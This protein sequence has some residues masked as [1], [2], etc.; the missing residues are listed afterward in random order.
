[1]PNDDKPAVKEQSDNWKEGNPIQPE[2][3]PA[4][5]R[6]DRLIESLSEMRRASEDLEARIAD[7]RRHNGMPID[8]AL[9]NPNWEREAADG[10]LD[11]PDEEDS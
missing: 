8:S 5:E 9:G 7:A 10:R 1:M 2:S 11:V 3:E 6:V 4:A